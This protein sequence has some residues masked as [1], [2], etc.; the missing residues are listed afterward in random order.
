MISIFLVG[1]GRPAALFGGT[2]R[3][4]T[5]PAWK[6]NLCSTSTSTATTVPA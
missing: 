6:D 2:E 5:D 4:Q 3:L 1:P